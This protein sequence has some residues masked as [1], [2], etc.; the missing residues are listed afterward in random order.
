MRVESGSNENGG[1]D[2]S[3]TISGGNFQQNLCSEEKYSEIRQEIRENRPHS[4][5]AGESESQTMAD[6]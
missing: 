1:E 2:A 6:L 5:S 4:R 3:S